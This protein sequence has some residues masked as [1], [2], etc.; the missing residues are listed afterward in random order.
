MEGVVLSATG[1]LLC[2]QAAHGGGSD[3]VSL[4]SLNRLRSDPYGNKSNVSRG[5]VEIFLDDLQLSLRE[6]TKSPSPCGTLL[7]FDTTPHSLG[8]NPSGLTKVG[9][10]L[11]ELGAALRVEVAYCTSSPTV[12]QMR[13]ELLLGES[14]DAG[15]N[16]AA[17]MHAILCGS[18]FS[19]ATV[20]DDAQRQ[21]LIACAVCHQQLSS[22][23]E[24]PLLP[25]VVI[26]LGF[27]SLCHIEALDVLVS[28]G[29]AATSCAF[30]SMILDGSPQRQQLAACLLQRGC[31]VLVDCLGHSA[32]F[33]V[34]GIEFPCDS[35]TLDALLALLSIDSSWGKTKITLSHG[36]RGFKTQLLNFGGPGN[37][38]DCSF[39]RSRLSMV[40][41]WEN[42]LGASLLRFLSEWYRAPPPAAVQAAPRIKCHMC[43][44]TFISDDDHYSKFGFEYCSTACLGK[45]RVQGWK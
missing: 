41:D 12:D 37:F 8:R 25:P 11:V 9:A 16:R 22:S 43:E 26:S 1:Y 10:R 39:A 42:M 45:H 24:W 28:H 6:S 15:G 34:P 20:L 33:Q 44:K 18:V 29:V 7:L 32:V 21:Q 23:P 14:H 4:R 3:S 13:Q 38:L 40:P 5:N 17:A 30:A 31:H 27:D 19:S 36:D 35:R 2:E